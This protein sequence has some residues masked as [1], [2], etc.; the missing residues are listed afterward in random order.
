MDFNTTSMSKPFFGLLLTIFTLVYANAQNVQK[1]ETPNWVKVVDI[2]KP[3]AALDG[4]GMQYLLFTKQVNFVVGERFYRQAMLLESSDMVSSHS[5]ISVGYD[6]SYQSVTLNAI[7]IYRGK[8]V[9]DKLATHAIQVFQRESN[10]ERSMYDGRMTAV[11]NLSDVRKGDVLEYSYTIHGVN[12]SFPKHYYSYQNFAFSVPVGKLLYRVLHSPAQAINYSLKNTTQ[13]P[14]V[15]ST[16]GLNSYEWNLANVKA[17]TYASNYP[18]WYEGEGSVSF[19]NYS[20]WGAVVNAVLPFYQQNDADINYLKKVIAKFK[21]EHADERIMQAIRFVQDDIR[22]LGFENGLNA[23]KPHEVKQV[24]NQ[25]FGDCK[26]K[27]FLLV[28]LLKAMGYKAFPV[29]VNSYSRQ[30]LD[31]L[32]VSPYDFDHVVVKLIYGNNE[33]FIDPTYS[34]QGGDLYNFNFPDYGKGLVIKAGNKKLDVI[35]NTS[36]AET[37]VLEDLIVPAHKDSSGIFQVSTEYYGSKADDMRSYFLNQDLASIQEDYLNYYSNIYEYISPI[38]QVQFIDDREK[39][40]LKTYEKYRIDSIWKKENGFREISTYPGQIRDISSVSREV[41]RKQPYFLY[42]PSKIKHETRIVLPEVWD[43]SPEKS[44]VAD[45]AYAYSYEVEYND[46][47]AKPFILVT[48][49][50]ETKA[51]HI[52]PEHFDKYL[53]D[54]DEIYDNLVF[55]LTYAD[56]ELASGN[57]GVVKTVATLLLI[58]FW[59]V[60]LVLFGFLAVKVFKT[61]DPTPE[62]WAFKSNKKIGSWLFIPLLG[63]IV[64]IPLLLFQLLSDEMYYSIN[65]WALYLDANSVYYSP[66]FVF[67]LGFEIVGQ[68]LL[69]SMVILCLVLFLKRRSSLPKLMVAFYS[70]N[71]IYLFL[72]VVICYLILPETE[73]FDAET[74]KALTR[75]V[76]GACLWIPVFLTSSRV[77]ETFVKTIKTVEYPEFEKETIA[78]IETVE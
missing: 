7:N 28:N 30:G 40:V 76:F 52:K 36:Q 27:S 48:H 1:G 67:A 13:Q 10:M 69:F 37:N 74:T 51:N 29:L 53:N 49:K 46:K 26:D 78:S 2:P 70:I 44:A 25:R 63:L 14:V 21:K 65:T 33:I 8:D 64:S 71:V 18:S 58:L 73:V 23:F 54:H 43:V 22:Y 68:L 42:Y 59:L 3:D 61:F 5:D 17:F 6:P 11:V 12:P 41:N 72:D 15:S 56:T 32:A 19:S 55:Q 75:G 66:G 50:Y 9:L 31:D 62:R 16:S 60:S 4:G 45:E 77:K 39:N 57:N 34:N 35:K 24:Y 47:N 38:A 20:D